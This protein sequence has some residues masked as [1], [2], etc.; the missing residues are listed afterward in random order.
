MSLPAISLQKKWSTYTAEFS[1]QAKKICQIK[2]TKYS[3]KIL[4]LR[5]LKNVLKSNS[6]FYSIGQYITLLQKCFAGIVVTIVY[7]PALL[8]NIFRNSRA[9]LLHYS[10]RWDDR[11][12]WFAQHP[13]VQRLPPQGYCGTIVIASGSRPQSSCL[14]S[15]SS[16]GLPGAFKLSALRLELAIYCSVTLLAEYIQW[17][18]ITSCKASTPPSQWRAQGKKGSEYLTPFT[19]KIKNSAASG[20]PEAAPQSRGEYPPHPRVGMIGYICRGLVS[21]API[22]RSGNRGIAGLYF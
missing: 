20:V 4:Y 12:W 11:A 14:S 1:L 10:A 15:Y 13:D 17:S 21:N 8:G 22:S 5:R 2:A 6:S 9:D 3:S 7:A 19:C 16:R 18:L